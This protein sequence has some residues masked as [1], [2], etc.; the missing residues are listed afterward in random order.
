MLLDVHY[1]HLLAVIVSPFVSKSDVL[2]C[3]GEV[4]RVVKELGITWK[5]NPRE[6]LAT[7]DVNEDEVHCP[8]DLP[9]C[10]L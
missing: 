1:T 4:E 5:Q 6:L 8:H 10:A 3:T 9:L 7:A 2:I